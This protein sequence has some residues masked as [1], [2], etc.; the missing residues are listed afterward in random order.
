MKKWSFPCRISMDKK[1][2]LQWLLADF[3]GI[4][5]E[6]GYYATARVNKE[7]LPSDGYVDVTVTLF[8]DEETIEEKRGAKR[9]PKPKAAR[10]TVDEMYKLKESGMPPKEI[11]NHAGI[12]IAT[13][14]R[15]M[16]EYKNSTLMGKGTIDCPAP[17][18]SK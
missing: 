12:S 18:G 4:S 17:G 9:G 15:R 11:A 8:M 7:H 14:F 13:Y 2:D 10:I 3:S 6:N 1:E 16:A 5:V